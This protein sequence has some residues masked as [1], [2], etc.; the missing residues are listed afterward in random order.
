MADGSAAL[1]GMLTAVWERLL[2]RSPVGPDENFFNLGSDS[3]LAME[4]VLRIKEASGCELPVALI[5]EAPTIASLAAAMRKETPWF[6]Q[7]F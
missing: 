2:G 5:F 3:L 6:R 1:I 7:L 4:L